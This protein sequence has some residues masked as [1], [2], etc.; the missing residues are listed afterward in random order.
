LITVAAAPAPAA[1]APATLPSAGVALPGRLGVS[2]GAISPGSESAVPSQF[3]SAHGDTNQPSNP[4]RVA[5]GQIHDFHVAP[6]A[7]QMGGVERLRQNSEGSPTSELAAAE[8]KATGFAPG[9]FQT[10]EMRLRELGATYY[11]LETLGPTADEYR[12]VCKV[13]SGV[14]ADEM[15]AF[16]SVDRDP[17]GAMNNVVRQVETWRSHLHD[18]P[19]KQAHPGN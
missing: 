8:T 5:E 16:F 2:R 18:A 3:A 1:S 4:D 17:L 7:H 15:L 6:V 14:R 10:A 9:Y 19:A 11:L 12:F 13:P